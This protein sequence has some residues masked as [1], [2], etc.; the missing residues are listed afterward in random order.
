M[1]KWR[2]ELI[3]KNT[4]LVYSCY[5]KYIQKT[6]FTVEHKD[7]FIQEGT[8]GLCK[9]A[10]TYNPEA[11]SA[12]STYAYRCILNQMRMYLRN[13]RGRYDNTISIETKI[14]NTD[15]NITYSDRLIG[16]F[17]FDHS[18]LLKQ[19]FEYLNKT[20]TSRNIKIFTMWLNGTRGRDISTI[21][22]ICQ[23]QVSRIVNRIQKDVKKYFS[24]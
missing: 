18:I 20:T 7:E 13:D 6:R 14:P 15:Q 5:N 11:G 22:G 10:K 21:F 12:F 24:K 23:P 16:N 3:T 2:E 9:A 17:D 4:K 19:V 1:E 8:V